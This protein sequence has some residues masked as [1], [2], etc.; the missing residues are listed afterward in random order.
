MSMDPAVGNFAQADV[1]VEGKPS[2]R[3]PNLQAGGA[4]R[5][6]RPR[7]HRDAR[8]HRHAPPPVRDR[9]AQLPGRRPAVRRA[10][11]EASRRTTSRRSCLTFAPQYRPEDVYISTL[12]GSL[13]ARCRRDDGARHLADP[14]LAAHSDATIAALR[15]SG[16]RAVFGYFESAG[17]VAGNQYPQTR[18]ASRRSTSQSATSC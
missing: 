1:L 4:Q 7:P 17:G 5:D 14:P 2:C 11:P 16:H 13:P 10:G 9:A 15:D 3:G 8:L 6:R 12:F 18:G